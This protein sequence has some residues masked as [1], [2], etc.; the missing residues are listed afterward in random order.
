VVAAR[1][2]RSEAW[3][4]EL[5][6]FHGITRYAEP[7]TRFDACVVAW[8]GVLAQGVVAIPL[9][10]GVT[11]VGFTPFGVVNALIAMFGYFSAVIAIINLVPAPRLDGA[12]AWQIVPHLWGRF[13]N[14]RGRSRRYTIRR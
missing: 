4:I 13:R 2:V 14:A 11:L 5:Y 9:I 3:S 1:R 7:E 8:G 10:L 12:L 6:P